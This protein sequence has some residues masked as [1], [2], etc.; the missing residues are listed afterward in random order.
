MY[1]ING[2]VT[3]FGATTNK[4]LVKAGYRIKI[5]Q[6]TSDACEVSLSHVDQGELGI[7]KFTKEDA[8]RAKLR[9]KA[10]TWTYYPQDML[11]W[12]CVA[13]ALK[14]YAPDAIGGMQIF[15]D[16]KEALHVGDIDLSEDNALDGFAPS[17]ERP[18]GA[19]Q[20]GHVIPKDAVDKA[21]VEIAVAI[22]EDETVHVE[23]IDVVHIDPEAVAEEIAQQ[24]EDAITTTAE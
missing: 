1:P 17:Q 23:E 20:L 14:M 24:Q 15:E 13:R 18:K 12:K 5:I 4:L 19:V 7:V 21:M 8:I 3:T 10:G 22:D 2:T 11:Y 16:V 9:G 6:Y